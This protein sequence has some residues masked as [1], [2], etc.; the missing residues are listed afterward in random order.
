MVYLVVEGLKAGCKIK[1]SSVAVSFTIKRG[2]IVVAVGLLSGYQ[3]PI[4]LALCARLRLRRKPQ[5]R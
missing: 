1:I 4:F 2:K 5:T 3:Y